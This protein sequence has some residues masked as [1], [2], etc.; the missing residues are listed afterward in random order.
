MTRYRANFDQVA[1]TIELGALAD[2]LESQL[3]QCITH[4]RQGDLAA[5]STLL[6]GIEDDLVPRLDDMLGQA[7][8]RLADLSKMSTPRPWRGFE[9]ISSP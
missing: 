4:V 7:G 5:A 9:S 3:D 8:N 2:E 1:D 6:P